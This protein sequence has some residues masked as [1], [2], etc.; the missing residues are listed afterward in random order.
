MRRFIFTL[1]LAMLAPMAELAQAAFAP[2]RNVSIVVP[3][4]PGGGTSLLL[5]LKNYW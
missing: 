3:F 4:P 1:I 5:T 2:T